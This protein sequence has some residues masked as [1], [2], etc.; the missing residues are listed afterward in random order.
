MFFKD[1]DSRVIRDRIDLV[2]AYE[3]Y[4]RVRHEFQSELGGSMRFEER[5]GRDYLYRRTRRH[6]VRKT[7]SL[8]P[9]G[10]ETE[11]ILRRFEQQKAEAEER[12]AALSARIDSGASVMRAL[13]HLRMPAIAARVIRRLNDS[14]AAARFRIVGTHALYVYEA[15]AGVELQSG[16]LATADLDVLVDDRAPLRVILS[17]EVRGLDAILKGVDGSFAQR[18]AGDYRLTNKDG[19]MVEFIRPEARPAHRPTPGQAT[20]IVG[21]AVPTPIA[22]LEWLVNVPA[23]SAAVID[24]R[25]YPVEVTAPAPAAWAAHKLWISAKE[26][27]QRDKAK[28]DREQAEAVFQLIDERLPGERLDPRR[29]SAIPREI[30]ALAL[31]YAEPRKGRTEPDW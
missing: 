7:L 23:L 2:A 3:E 20:G 30:A 6:G 19:F 18:R 12:L 27:R 13:G 21:D 17:E 24:D 26:D 5:S 29:H 25:G 28:R 1:L 15:A 22:G 14:P 10:P 16:F 31:P 4:R 11:E 9:R 8:G